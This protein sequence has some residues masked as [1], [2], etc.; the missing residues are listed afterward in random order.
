[1]ES[2]KI[3]LNFLLVFLVGVAILAFFIFRP[4]LYALIMALIF[5]VVCQPVYRRILKVINRF[6][7]LAALLTT[8]L[9]IIFILTPLVLLG[10]QVFKEA[11]QV[12]F[13]LT[14]NS[15]REV[16][17]NILRGLADQFH[18]FLP[19]GFSLNF[20]QYIKQAA[21]WLVQNLGSL[22]S[23][24]ANFM[25]NAFIFL[26]AF[27]YLL[28]NGDD[29]KKIVLRLSPLSETENEAILNKLELSINS[30]VRG[31]LVVGLI[32]GA[33]TAIGLTI[34]GV[35]SAV[36]WGMIAAITSLIPGVGT[37]IVIIPAIAYLFLTGQT[38]AAIGLAVWG[39]L[40]VGLIDNFLGPKI[41]GRGI[42]LH[43][44]LVILSVL[45]GIV[46]FGPMGFILGPLV[47]SLFF[48]LSDIYSYLVKKI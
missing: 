35:P 3:Q 28:K 44:L 26:L 12:Y 30:V 45:G 21:T 8:I 15:G 4:F 10:V 23:N 31:N 34:F 38:V 22:F 20:D 32:Q 13:S 41:V 17:M 19:S 48:A 37:S 7:S 11:L 42:K 29:L 46:F 47:L 16:V 36:L 27:Y 43:P 18:Q 39:V 25:A 2:R 1:M 5:A 14:E 9:I 24:A 6:P 40:A 33:L